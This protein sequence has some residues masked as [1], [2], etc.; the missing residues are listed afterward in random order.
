MAWRGSGVAGQ[1]LWPGG[2]VG[3]DI[4]VLYSTGL[5]THNAGRCGAVRAFG[6]SV[7]TSGGIGEAWR[8][9]ARRGV[10]WHGAGECAGVGTIIID[11]KMKRRLA[12]LI[13]E[14]LY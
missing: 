5:G 3:C 9:V 1:W 13:G 8:G 10:A 2:V 14:P 11:R 4:R 6:S 12:R 7:W